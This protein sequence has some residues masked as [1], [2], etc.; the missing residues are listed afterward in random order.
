MA[1]PIGKMKSIKDLV[2]SILHNYPQSRDND[3]YLACVV[4]H[5]QVRARHEGEVTFENFLTMYSNN[6][7]TSSDTITRAARNI[8]EEN[9]NLRGEGH[10][11]RKQLEVETRMNIR[12]L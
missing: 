1:N 9:P 10:N 5:K 12:N 6:M 8:K 7:L 11:K 4:W 2:E 3:N